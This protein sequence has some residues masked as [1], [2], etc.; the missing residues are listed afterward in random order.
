MDLNGALEALPKQDPNTLV[1]RGDLKCCPALKASIWHAAASQREHIETLNA[2]NKEL[3]ERY[4]DLFKLS[5]FY[6]TA[7]P[8]FFEPFYYVPNPEHSLF[9]AGIALRIQSPGRSQQLAAIDDLAQDE[10]MWK[11]V[12]EGNGTLS[13]ILIAAAQLHADFLFLADMIADPSFELT[14][15]DER[16]Q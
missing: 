6:D 10:L 15:M 14:L 1:F 3:N 16:H 9:L 7:T 5:G 11:K 2:D 4:R 13:S 12:F 8:S